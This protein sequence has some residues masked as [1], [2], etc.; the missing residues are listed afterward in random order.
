MFVKIKKYKISLLN[1]LFL[2]KYKKDVINNLLFE[3]YIY[4]KNKNNDNNCC[5]N[6]IKLSII[7]FYDD[8]NLLN[9][10]CKIICSNTEIK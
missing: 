3:T 4:K 10:M 5:V 8:C 6:I 2:N 9:F 7:Y 1:K